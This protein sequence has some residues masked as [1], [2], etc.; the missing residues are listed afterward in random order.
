MFLPSIVRN[1]I[2]AETD[3]TERRGPSALAIVLPL[4]KFPIS[5][6]VPAWGQEERMINLF[7]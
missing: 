2:G 4:G 7:N 1:G 5:E 3:G 6:E